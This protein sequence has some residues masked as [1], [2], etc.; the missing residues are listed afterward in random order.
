MY[1]SNISFNI[2]LTIK[3][4]ASKYQISWQPTIRLWYVTEDIIKKHFPWGC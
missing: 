2:S 4:L 1:E 3:S